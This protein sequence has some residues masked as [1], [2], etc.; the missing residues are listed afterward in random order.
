MPD[1]LSIF[2]LLREESLAGSTLS[3]YRMYTIARSVLSL[4]FFGYAAY[5]LLFRANSIVSKLKLDE[6]LDQ[7]QL[8]VD[9][10]PKSI[11]TAAIIIVSGLVLMNNIPDMLQMICSYFFDDEFPGDMAVPRG[12][13]FIFSAVKII[14]ALLLIGERKRIVAMLD[15]EEENAGEEAMD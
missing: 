6:G 12:H 7:T 13:A 14:A 10:P 2:F 8:S 4:A 1:F 15:K 9:F 11:L 5:I 3:G